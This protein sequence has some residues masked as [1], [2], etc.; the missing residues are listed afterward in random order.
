MF[1]YAN[2]GKKGEYQCKVCECLFSEQNRFLKESIIK[3]PHCLKTLES[4]KELK[5]FYVF[6]CKN[7]ACSYYSTFAD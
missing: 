1:I 5:D 7:N 3:C 6:K 4:I 2:N